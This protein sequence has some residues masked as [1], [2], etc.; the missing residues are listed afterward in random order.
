[1]HTR[2]VFVN[3]RRSERILV[4]LKRVKGCRWQ[5]LDEPSK[6]NRWILEALRFLCVA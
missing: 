3:G 5:R 6:D 1:V 4:V 2:L